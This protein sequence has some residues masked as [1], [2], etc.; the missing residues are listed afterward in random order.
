MSEQKRNWRDEYIMV[1]AVVESIDLD[2]KFVP[3]MEDGKLPT[4][5]YILHITFASGDKVSIDT[6]FIDSEGYSD[7]KWQRVSLDPSGECILIEAL[8][9]PLVLTWNI[10]R[11]MTDWEFA[12]DTVKTHKDQQIEAGKLLR[13]LR[14]K[15]NSTPQ[16]IAEKAG[17]GLY[18]LALAE[19][20]VDLEM[21]MLWKILDAIGRNIA[22]LDD[23]PNLTCGCGA[24]ITLDQKFCPRCGLDIES[25][26]RG[27]GI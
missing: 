4:G 16:E 21:T 23:P 24:K 1:S 26:L 20:G 14:K 25:A 17:I 8:P 10:I 5:N 22:D 2:I 15:I 12:K 6:K 18:K 9:G 27:E 19:E 13:N 3:S 7:I 11:R